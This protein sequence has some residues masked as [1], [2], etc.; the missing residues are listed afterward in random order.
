MNRGSR[1]DAGGYL[2]IFFFFNLVEKSFL[3]VKKVSRKW[4]RLFTK[5]KIV[6]TAWE[7]EE[8]PVVNFLIFTTEHWSDK[9]HGNYIYIKAT[10]NYAMQQT[11]SV[12]PQPSPIP[13]GFQ[14]L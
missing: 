14:L 4:H 3:R 1:F 10:I 2:H 6:L 11:A 7:F 12:K 8:K 9:A 13:S 5:G